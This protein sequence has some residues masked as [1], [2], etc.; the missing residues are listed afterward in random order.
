MTKITELLSSVRFWSAVMISLG[1]ALGASH[2]WFVIG[3]TFLVDLGGLMLG[4]RSFD[5]I[6]E[7]VKK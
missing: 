5:K 6:L 1:M 4:V 3:S 7:T 2:D